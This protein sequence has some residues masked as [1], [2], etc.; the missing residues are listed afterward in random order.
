M[1]GVGT[2]GKILPEMADLTERQ[3]KLLKAVVEEY[4]KTAEPV[5]SVSLVE[6]EGLEVSSA[7]V[8]NEMARL[9]KLGF[10]NQ[11][12]T[13]AGR[14]PTTV[15]LRFYLANLMEEDE[16]PV[17]KE[18][19]FKQR[20]WQERFELDKTLRQAVLAL[21]EATGYL[22]FVS[23]G[24]SRLF[25][26]GAS[27]IL[28]HPEFFDIEVT[29]AVLGLFDDELSFGSLLARAKSGEAL[30]ILMG[31]EL[32]TPNL[33]PCALVFAPYGTEKVSGHLGVLG[34]ARMAYA[35]VLPTVRYFKN[36][37]AEL[38]QGW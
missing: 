23:G 7:T 24:S 35:R 29:R 37:L 11:P 26:A 16:L 10:L 9:I 6:K 3:T 31:E 1:T 19:A 22:A 38:G 25:S 30:H 32:E 20:L 14:V 18:V 36:L 2:R 27:S 12:H 4:I 33:A 28:D 21:A 8:R 5:G 15:G 34:P 17:L 13:S